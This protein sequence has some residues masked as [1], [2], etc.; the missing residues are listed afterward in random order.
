MIRI[1]GRE[2]DDA[3]LLQ[4]F[5][6]AGLAPGQQIVQVE[7]Q[8]GG[9]ADVPARIQ[10]QHALARFVDALVD[11]AAHPVRGQVAGVEAQFHRQAEQ[12]NAA[13]LVDADGWLALEQFAG[14][15][16]AAA[17]NARLVD[18]DLPGQTEVAVGLDFGLAGDDDLLWWRR[19]F[20]YGVRLAQV[21]DVQTG[22]VT[23]HP[24]DSKSKPV[25]GSS[26]DC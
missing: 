21:T 23:T 18:D 25:D 15:L 26:A 17:G 10:V 2:P 11:A 4:V 12:A 13:V 20:R 8:H 5:V 16:Q 19:C 7:P 24:F 3:V 9:L 1:P 6:D 22:K 14:I